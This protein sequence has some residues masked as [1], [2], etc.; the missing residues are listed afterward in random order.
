MKF[1]SCYV[2]CFVFAWILWQRIATTNNPSGRWISQTSYPSRQACTRDASRI[3]DQLRNEHLRRG[4][5]ADYIFNQGVGGFSLGNGE[6]H[7]FMCYSSDFD[8]RPRN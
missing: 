6:R 5:G 8:P 7:I 4:L 2:F 1:V 3:I